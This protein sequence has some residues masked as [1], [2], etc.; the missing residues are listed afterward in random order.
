VRVLSPAHPRSGR[1]VELRA[2]LAELG[3]FPEAGG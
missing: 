3:L 2:L 1:H